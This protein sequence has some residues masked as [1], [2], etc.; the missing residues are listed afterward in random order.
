MS[1]L[2]PLT[3][4]QELVV[5]DRSAHLFVCACPGAGKTRTVV[6]RFLAR[7]AELSSRRGIAVLSFSR[8]ATKEI[9]RRCVN[10]GLDRLLGFPN[11]VGTLDAFFFRF[12]FRPSRQAMVGRLVQVLDS[13]DAIGA[14]VRVGGTRSAGVSLDAFPAADGGVRFD[15]TRL[16]G[17]EAATKT[18]IEKHRATWE[19]SAA[20]YLHSLNAKGYYTCEAVRGEVH[21]LVAASVEGVILRALASRFEEIVVDEA[22]DCDEAQIGVLEAMAGAG[23]RLVVVADPEQAIYEFR[24]AR[25]DLLKALTAGMTRKE[26]TGNWRS[27]PAICGLANS[28]RSTAF[29]PMT[30]VGKLAGETTPVFVIPYKG[31]S[32]N[33]A[34]GMFVSAARAESIKVDELLLLSHRL[35]VALKTAGL[36]HEESSGG[37]MGARIARLAGRMSAGML[38][39]SDAENGIRQI[40]ELLLRRLGVE[41]EGVTIADLCEAKGVEPRWLR[42]AAFSVLRCVSEGVAGRESVTTGD[43]TGLLRGALERLAPPVDLVWDRSVKTLIPLRSADEKVV[44]PLRRPRADECKTTIVSTIHA[45]KGTESS[46]A[47]VVLSAR[48]GVLDDLLGAWETKGELEAKRVAYVAVTRA[49]R[50]LGVAVPDGDLDRLVRILEASGVNYRLVGGLNI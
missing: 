27:T 14:R 22:Q 32:A 18:E 46:A 6:E 24:A 9:K 43:A 50:V 44:V 16:R 37:G 34:P 15:A 30:A 49:A 4:E 23:V 11:Y 38:R 45:A 13:W 47:L 26:L 5:K 48:G 36:D 25:P 31:Q 2:P 19:A 29:T 17:R 20:R 21:T 39:G 10:E 41:T 35:I 12:F 40:E 28:M 1:V 8:M 7:A 42:G 3:P 33:E